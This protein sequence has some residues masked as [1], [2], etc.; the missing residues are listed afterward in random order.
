MA[1][2]KKTKAKRKK[3][4]KRR[5]MGR[6]RTTKRGRSRKSTRR[7]PKRSRKRNAQPGTREWYF[8]N[9]MVEP[10]DAERALQW[11]GGQGSALYSFG[12]TAMSNYVSPSMAQRAI[13]ELDSTKSSIK[14]KAKK[15][16]YSKSEARKDVKDLDS[17]MGELEKYTIFSDEFESG[18]DDQNDGFDTYSMELDEVSFER[19]EN[20]TRRGIKEHVAC[21]DIS[22]KKCK[23]L[24][25]VYKK[26]RKKGYGKTRS[27]KI[28]RGAVRRSKKGSKGTRKRNAFMEPEYVKGTFYDVE[29][30]RGEGMLVPGDLVGKSPKV[31]DFKDY[32][33][34]TPRSF[35]KVEGW[36]VRLSAPGYM[37]AT[38]WSG[39]FKTEAAARKHVEDHYEVDPDSGD[40]LGEMENNPRGRGRGNSDDCLCRK[41]AR[42][43]A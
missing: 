17:L 6:K 10:E 34:G 28:A 18:E 20:R 30:T 38:D 13:D 9:V 29:S 23:Q 32:V 25:T 24:Q 7:V 26:Q 37:D 39:P 31:T 40:E 2:A 19:A 4:G 14:K 16:E 35:E 5:A 11:H 15:G 3:T 8:R 22:K 36:F 41:L 42:G 43:E 27:A 1:R 12:S 21:G 33:E